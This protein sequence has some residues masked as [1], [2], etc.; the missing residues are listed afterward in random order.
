MYKRKLAPARSAAAR[1]DMHE[2]VKVEEK[3]V[4]E[5]IGVAG[6]GA[7]YSDTEVDM[8][9]A[10]FRTPEDF[11]LYTHI[12]V[13]PKMQ[14][15][16][17]VRA[18][19][20]QPVSSLPLVRGGAGSK[21]WDIARED[22]RQCRMNHW[23]DSMVMNA[24][25]V[26]AAATQGDAH[27]LLTSDVLAEMMRGTEDPARVFARAVSA[28]K[29]AAARFLLLPFNIRGVHWAL[30]AADVRG[31]T[32]AVYDSM[33]GV[34]AKFVTRV[35]AALRRALE[36]VLHRSFATQPVPAPPAQRDT[37]S[38]GV[39][40][41]HFLWSLLR[42][43]ARYGGRG[44]AAPMPDLTPESTRELLRDMVLS[45]ARGRLEGGLWLAG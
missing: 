38:C 22:V 42:D 14:R 4:E 36:R 44:R 45:V 25:V 26:M 30:A 3:K 28:P 16:A 34:D 39:F 10:L 17:N 7:L 24:L 29:L 5:A 20:A 35:R 1:A 6:D 37:T 23:V 43:E 9:P 41:I 18:W 11:A 33:R 12:M 21:G 8:D 2:T 40:T 27:V 15:D 13:R 31:G 19:L 32:V